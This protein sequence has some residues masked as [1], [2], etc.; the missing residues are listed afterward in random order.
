MRLRINVPPL[1]KDRICFITYYLVVS[2]EGLMELQKAR[3]AAIVRQALIHSMNQLR[4]VLWPTVIVLPD[5][6]M[7][8]KSK[9][10]LHMGVC[11]PLR[12]KTWKIFCCSH[13]KRMFIHLLCQAA[14]CI[15]ASSALK[16]SVFNFLL[17]AL[18]LTEC[19]KHEEH[20][21]P[22]QNAAGKHVNSRENSDP[23]LNFR[24]K[25]P[26]VDFC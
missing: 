16:C 24:F 14:S 13:A 8:S 11:S 10:E 9:A 18:S 17:C 23:I 5:G 20:L 21:A 15:R 25:I 3:E 6:M 22:S 1:W 7:A 2:K 12:D 19:I 4:C 26:P